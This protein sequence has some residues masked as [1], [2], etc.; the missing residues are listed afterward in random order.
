MVEEAIN[1]E[2]REKSTVGAGFPANREICREFS[3]ERRR[4]GLQWRQKQRKI[5]SLTENTLCDK[6]GKISVGNREKQGGNR[7]IDP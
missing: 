7:D 1:T 5:S 6:T 4:Q 2:M 3:A